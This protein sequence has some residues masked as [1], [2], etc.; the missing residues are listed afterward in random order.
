MR[1]E[2]WTLT[3]A[4]CCKI[5]AFELW[6]WRRM[7]RIPWTAKR[8]NASI[9]QEIGHGS[10]LLKVIDRQELSYFGHITRRQGNCLENTILTERLKDP[11]DQEDLKPDGLTA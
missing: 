4:D 11:V 9:L 1:V 7:V 2:T 3:K 5:Q 6:C 8:T 10:C